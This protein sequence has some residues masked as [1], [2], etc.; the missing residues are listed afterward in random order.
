MRF[1]M[2]IKCK[3]HAEGGNSSTAVFLIWEAVAAE[4]T[5]EWEQEQGS[6]C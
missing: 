6:I 3:L 4:Q 2:H 5:S 1:S